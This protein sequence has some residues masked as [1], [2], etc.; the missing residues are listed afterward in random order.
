ML[1]GAF[2]RWLSHASYMMS[3]AASMALSSGPPPNLASKDSIT[4]TSENWLG[5]DFP[6]FFLFRGGRFSMA[7]LAWVKT[8]K[9]KLCTHIQQRS[10]LCER[11]RAPAC[12]SEIV[13]TQIGNREKQRGRVP[14]TTPAIREQAV[15]DE[16]APTRTRACWDSSGV[17]HSCGEMDH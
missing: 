17:Y 1:S 14:R 5:A 4:C 9:R 15:L 10:H 3:W 16:T 2:Y 8:R 6:V 7:R 11:E 12:C 13:S